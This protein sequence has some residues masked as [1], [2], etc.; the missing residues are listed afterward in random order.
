MKII[1]HGFKKKE[2]DTF[3]E[4]FGDLNHGTTQYYT[5]QT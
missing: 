5:K 2:R 4:Y 3:D 1:S